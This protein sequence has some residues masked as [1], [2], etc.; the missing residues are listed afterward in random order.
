MSFHHLFRPCL[1]PGN[2]DIL[3]VHSVPYQCKKLV[4]SPGN[5]RTIKIKNCLLVI[6][7]HGLILFGIEI[8]TYLT[9]SPESSLIRRQFFVNKVDTTGLATTP[10]KVAELVS[11]YIKYLYDINPNSQLHTVKLVTEKPPPPP[12]SEDN[13]TLNA[14]ATILQNLR[15]SSDYFKSISYYNKGSPSD[16]A[17]H[18]YSD[19]VPDGDLAYSTSLSLFTRAADDY[20][21]PLSHKNVAKHLID[22]NKLLIWWLKLIDSLPL[23]WDSCRVTIPGAEPSA[24]AKYLLHVSPQWQVGNIFN[25]LYPSSLAIYNIPVFPDDPKGRFLEHLVVENRYK[26]VDVDQFWEELGYRQEFR[27]GN[28]VG[29][30]GCQLNDTPP[31]PTKWENPIQL[32]PKVY[33]SLVNLIKGEDFSVQSDVASL[34]RTAIPQFFQKLGISNYYVTIEGK[35]SESLDKKPTITTVNSLPVKRKTDVTGEVNNLTSLIKRKPEAKL[36]DNAAVN[37]ISGLV[38]KKPETSVIETGPTVNNISG[39]V[40]KKPQATSSDT[41]TREPTGPH[42]NVTPLTPVNNITGVVRKKPKK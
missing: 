12:H 10:I 42:A 9:L 34:T 37:N 36:S 16:L 17:H 15:R 22:G 14:L 21:F 20:L 2:Y 3:L 8:F 26:T 7:G 31:S 30:I 39:L 40:K 29:I 5:L 18:N 1:P 38:K 4:N 25:D 13:E 6:D 28:V 41:V 11:V 27:L 35:K 23:T 19:L 33:K 24:I 32:T